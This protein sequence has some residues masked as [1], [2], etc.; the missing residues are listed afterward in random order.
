MAP[1][2]PVTDRK[3]LSDLLAWRLSH[4]SVMDLAK[5]N[6]LAQGLAERIVVRVP[7]AG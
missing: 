5:Q 6:R 7:L 2:P 4:D 1:R 3:A